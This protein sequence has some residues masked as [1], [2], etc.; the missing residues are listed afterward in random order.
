V[1]QID[2]DL[3]V[4]ALDV[5]TIAAGMGYLAAL[6]AFSTIRH[7]RGAELMHLSWWWSGITGGD[8]ASQLRTQ[9][10]GF[11]TDKHTADFVAATDDLYV[12]DAPGTAHSAG[13]KLITPLGA[14]PADN[15]QFMEV[16]NQVTDE[17]PTVLPPWIR[18][19]LDYDGVQHTAGLLYC[20]MA[21][22]G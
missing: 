1:K 5:T 22:Y 19:A 17:L 7:G 13:N 11:A 14:A 9:I 6:P 21:L 15:D 2:E 3:I 16:I 12:S 20:R 4:S 8:A 10:H 18:I